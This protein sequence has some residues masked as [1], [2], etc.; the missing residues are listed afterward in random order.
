MDERGVVIIIIVNTFAHTAMTNYY[1][2]INHQGE[3]RAGGG[4][5][6]TKKRK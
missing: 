6:G 5:E 4:G 1:V 2:T 3:R